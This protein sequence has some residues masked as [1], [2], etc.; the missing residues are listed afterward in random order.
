MTFM[1]W[2]DAN[3]MYGLLLDFVAD[4]RMDCNADSDRERFLSELLARLRATERE[5]AEASPAVIIR[6]LRETQESIDPEF[7]GDP[8]VEH[9][10]DCIEEIERVQG[11]EPAN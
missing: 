7:A 4:A 9:L 5:L 1:D 3:G 11:D 2:S 8:V 6:T 10:R